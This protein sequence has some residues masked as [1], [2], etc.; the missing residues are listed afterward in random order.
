MHAPIHIPLCTYVTHMCREY[1]TSA[2]AYELLEECGRGVSATVRRSRSEGRSLQ[3]CALI[4][5][6]ELLLK[7]T[8]KLNVNLRRCG[9]LYANP[10]TNSWL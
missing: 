4:P 6:T 1:P 7:V 9:V 5:L 3:T 8:H 10:S 2:D